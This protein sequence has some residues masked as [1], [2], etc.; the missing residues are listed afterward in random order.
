MDVEYRKMRLED[1]DGNWKA[2]RDIYSLYNAHRPL[3]LV[4]DDA[5]WRGY[6]SRRIVSRLKSYAVVLFIARAPDG[7]AAGYLLAEYSKREE[8]REGSVFDLFI[9]TYE[10]GTV[11]GHD[12]AALTLL[13]AV[14]GGTAQGRVGGSI[15]LPRDGQ[16]DKVVRAMFGPGL[17]LLDCD[18][19]ALSLNE[20]FGEEEIA[21]T[22]AAPGALFW[23]ID[24]F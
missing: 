23:I 4:R 2:V 12:E 24:D 13:A 9:T 11:P 18:M 3:S 16:V 10:L 19:M 5:Y 6:V 17:R 7:Q 15:R 22:F 14:M 21:A 1:E 20:G 8:V